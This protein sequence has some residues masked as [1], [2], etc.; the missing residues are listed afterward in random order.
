ML[1][2]LFQLSKYP[3]I[4]S[5][6]LRSNLRAHIMD[7]TLFG[8]AMSFVSVNTILPVFVQ[9]AGGNAIAI[10]SVPVLW[11]IG[12]NLPQAIFIRLTPSDGAIHPSVLRYALFHRISFLVVGFFTL[13]ILGQIP[14][15][16][17]VPLL[18]LTFFLIAVTGSLGVSPWFH[19]FTK[20]TPVRLRGRLI[21]L[22]QLAS[23]T[24]G[25]FGGW[26]VT[27]ILSIL[28]FPANF[29]S[30]FFI[31]F[32]LSMLS[33]L[34]LRVLHEPTSQP[35]GARV[36][37]SSNIIQQARDVLSRDRHFRNFLVVDAFTLMSM[38]ASAFYSVHAI[39]KFRLPP[40]YAGTFTAIVMASMAP[41]NVLFGYLADTFGHKLNL[42][43]LAMAAVA[44]SLTAL[45]AG[46]ILI[47]GLA[48]FFM[49]LSVSLQGISRLSFLAELCTETERPVYVALTNTLTAPTVGVGVLLGWLARSFG[50][51][52][53]FVAGI[54]F[55]ALA[56][57]RLYFALPEPRHRAASS[58]PERKG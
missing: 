6:A 9:Q 58:E 15:D 27:V 52:P 13:F 36:E 50:Y 24:L 8:F 53:V 14:R 56:L 42:V 20:T 51:E 46:N 1:A 23:S 40:A 32:L 48:F 55:G 16:T 44:A 17:S 47:Y 49:A 4:D 28:S 34:Y 29:A 35:T 37:Y 10:G 25:I 7:G 19:L 18:L 41:G 54:T 2:K 39:E 38:T 12:L 45:L 21:A 43:L 31:A 57:A 26:A 33:Y 3:A 11:T 5:P 30:L 22:R